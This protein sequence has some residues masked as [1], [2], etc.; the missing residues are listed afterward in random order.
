[1]NM[2]DLGPHQLLY[3]DLHPHPVPRSHS[4]NSAS[5]VRNSVLQVYIKATGEVGRRAAGDV[6]DRCLLGVT[7]YA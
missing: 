7:T 1:M 3:M 6:D 5:T 4:V 2:L